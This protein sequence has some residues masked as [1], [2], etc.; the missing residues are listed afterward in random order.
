MEALELARGRF[1]T[2]EVDVPC[3]AS[4]AAP[5]VVGGDEGEGCFDGAGGEQ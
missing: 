1:G 3:V 4:G 2:V 5:G